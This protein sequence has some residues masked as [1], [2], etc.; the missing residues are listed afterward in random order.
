[1]ASFLLTSSRTFS[2]S[3]WLCEG[4]AAHHCGKVTVTEANSVTSSLLWEECILGHWDADSLPA[5]LP[6]CRMRRLVLAEYDGYSVFHQLPMCMNILIFMSEYLDNTWK[7]ASEMEG[8]VGSIE[9]WATFKLLTAKNN[10]LATRLLFFFQ[11]FHM[12]TYLK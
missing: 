4:H 7:L 9:R 5:S 1:M 8:E 11:G 10:G 3:L 12:M 6:H 2:E